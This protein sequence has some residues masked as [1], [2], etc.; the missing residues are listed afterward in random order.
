MKKYLCVV[1]DRKSGKQLASFE[2]ESTEDY[3][4]RHKAV[5]LFITYNQSVAMEDWYVDSCEI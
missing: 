3:Y 5:D 2:I 1:V 4:A